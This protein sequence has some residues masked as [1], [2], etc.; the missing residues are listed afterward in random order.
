MTQETQNAK[1]QW[2]VEKL[3]YTEKKIKE[4]I[5]YF[6]AQRESCNT[7]VAKNYYEGKRYQ[8]EMDLSSIQFI[9]KTVEE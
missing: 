9:L 2:L 7:S 1:Y 3:K 6:K 4:D 5:E 8:A